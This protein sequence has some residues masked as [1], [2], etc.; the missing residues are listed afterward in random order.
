[1]PAAPTSDAVSG[2]VHSSTTGD[3]DSGSLAF[4]ISRGP[5]TA[6]PS[7]SSLRSALSRHAVVPSRF[8]VQVRRVAQRSPPPEPLPPAG[9]I[10]RRVRRR[11]LIAA[12]GSCKPLGR[13]WLKRWFPALAGEVPAVAG[14][15]YEAGLVIVR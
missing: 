7:A 9:A 10:Q 13:G 15:V 2:G 1:M 5:R 6:A 4:A 8:P 3:W 12:H 14:G 11:T